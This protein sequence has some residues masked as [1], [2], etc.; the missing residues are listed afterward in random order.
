MGP[1]PFGRGNQEAIEAADKEL[2]ASMGPRPFGRGN[3]P[4]RVSWVFGTV[5]LQWGRGRSAAE[6]RATWTCVV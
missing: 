5:T 3:L 6:I 4:A 2:L 1:R